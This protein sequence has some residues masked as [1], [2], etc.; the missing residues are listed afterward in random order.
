MKVKVV[1]KKTQ[2]IRS[3][4][5]KAK[6]LDPAMIAKALGAEGP[7]KFE[8]ATPRQKMLMMLAKAV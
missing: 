7:I 6:T 5:Q 4:S 8:D 1:G 3:T 2:I